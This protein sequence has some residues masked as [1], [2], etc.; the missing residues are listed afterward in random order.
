MGNF[1]SGNREENDN[2]INQDDYKNNESK[3]NAEK[4]SADAMYSNLEEGTL[5]SYV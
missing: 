1:I 3:F 2:I 5:N 4:D